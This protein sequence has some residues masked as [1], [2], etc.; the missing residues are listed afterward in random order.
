M[1]RSR[2]RLTGSIVFLGLAAYAASAEAAFVKHRH[3][4]HRVHHSATAATRSPSFPV[5]VDR[6]SD[7]SPGTDNHYFSDTRGP[8][9]LN[10]QAP[11]PIGPSYFQR[12][13]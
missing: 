10:N 1:T 5:Y 8:N 13:W 11:Y 4:A 2:R 12:W 9:L 7:Y 3:P 6:G